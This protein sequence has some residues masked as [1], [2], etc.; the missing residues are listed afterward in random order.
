MRFNH[1]AA[2]RCT[3]RALG[4]FAFLLLL[5]MP[6]TA[7]AQVLY[8][9][10]TGH[11]RDASGAAIPGATV[12]ATNVRTGLV[13]ETTTD[14]TGNYDIP[15]VPTGRYNVSVKASGFKSVTRENVEVTINTTSRVDLSVQVGEVAETVIITAEAAQLKTD[16][17]EVSSELTNK[18]LQNLPVPLGRNY[19]NLFKTLPGFTPPADAHSVP[20]NPSRSLVFN[21]NG[22]SRSSNNTRIDGVSTTNI[23][24]P[25]VTAYI[26][27]LESIEVVNVATNSFDAEQGLAGGAAINV[28]IKSGTNEFHGSAFEYHANQH[29]KARDYFRPANQPKGK[30]IQNQYGGTIG[31]PIIRNKLFFFAS[32]EGTKNRQNDSLIQSVP[33][34]AIRNGDF[35][36]LT[37]PNG[38]PII[39]Y[40]PLTGNLDGTGRTQISCNGVA[41]V[42]CQDRIHPIIKKI[43]PL[44]PAP[45]LPGEQNNFF[46]GAPFS[47]DRWTLDSKINYNIT[48]KLNVYGRYSVLDF[49]T[50][51]E[52]IFGKALQGRAINSSNPGTGSGK[53]HNFSIGGVYTITPNLIFDANFG[54]VRM[55]AGVEQSDIEENRGLDFLGLPGTNGPNRF[56]G[57][58]PLFD[59]TTYSDFGTTD[60]FMP[61]TR[62]DDQYQIVAN[63]NWLRGAHNVRFGMDIYRQKMN[64][65]QPEFLGGGSLGARGGF[66]FTNDVTRLNG[67]GA[68]TQYH[69]WA[70]FLLGLPN[71]VGKLELDVAPYT[72]RNWQYSFYGRDQW[73]VN[74]KMTFSFGTRWEYFPVPLRAD[75]G[76]ERYN[77]NTNMM[78]IGCI[79]SVPCDL[80]VEVS[81]ALF[82]PRVGLAYRIT[83]SF[84]VRAGYGLTND[85]YALARPLRTNHPVLLNLN[86]QAPNNFQFASRLEQG[87]PV[88]PP[89]SLGNG[90]I[91]IPGNVAAVTLPDKFD[92]GY[93]QSWNLSL[94]K[95]IGW[96]FVGEAAYVATRQVRQ[97]G[98]IELNWAPIGTGNNGRQLRQRF[99][100]DASTQLVAPVGGSSY[101]GLQTRLDRRFSDFYELKMNYTFSKSLND[102]GLPDSDNT[103][104][105]AIPQFFHLD[106]S[107]SNFDRRH[108]F[109]LTNIL[110]LPFGRGRKYLSGAN[111]AVS[112]VVSGWQ[113]NNIVSWYSGVPFSVT[114]DGGALNA[115]GSSQRADLIK[116]E[117]TINSDR[118]GPGQKYFDT[119]A[120]AQPVGARFGTA[121]WNILRGPVV[122]QWDF[123]LFR[124]FQLTEK[125]NLQ[126]RAESFNFTN[127]PQWGN[128]NGNVNANNFGEISSV[129]ATERQ[130]RF[131]LR[132]GF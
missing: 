90:I 115:P 56:E 52:T 62:S 75:R 27:A 108:N 60:T 89:V 65:I 22:A 21:V 105:I 19:Q 53:T 114:A 49:Y 47:F 33:T 82:A 102:S 12:T 131:A 25:H 85:P 44:I 71:R 54:F 6:Q 42:I 132:L 40:D 50:V 35:R 45:N 7:D 38:Q 13:R 109:Q 97:L 77:V 120:F 1:A 39:I 119:T 86:V 92:R 58:F 24:L 110:E 107:L 101:H 36:G 23:W 61:Y 73:Q 83:P 88:V 64:H 10:I 111:R 121:A 84:V 122:F 80:G 14:S 117:V 94:Q 125:V 20:S 103:R 66:V 98:L 129:A 57:G 55:N 5:W 11:V 4:V 68:G 99:G 91:P 67:G 18:P 48:S 9:S 28:Q 79:G 127:T 29:L 76:F 112:S 113:V 100:R 30:F 72:T 37:Y 32:Y 3:R 106:K 17:A 78:E 130:Y 63:V 128:P 51:N 126:F 8:G 31:G 59:V 34:M 16:R 46:V 116:S 96:G 95:E 124:Q 93:V 123:G 81:K 74:Q 43:L 87:I 118:R 2:A 70:S 69:G 26:P 41:N 15:T 104:R